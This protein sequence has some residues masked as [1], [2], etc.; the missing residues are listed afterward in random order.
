MSDPVLVK[1]LR[2][3]QAFLDQLPAKV[4]KNILRSA[5]RQGAN[6][7]K[8]EA[9]QQ[10]ASNGNVK[11]GELS[12]GLKVSTNAKG[13]RVTASLKAKGKHGHIAHWIEFGTRPH[14]IKGK[15]G[16]ALAFA[17]G[18]YKAINHPGMRPRP[19]L[20][21]ALDGAAGMALVAV[22]EA[23]KKRLTKE[24]IDAS[25]VEIDEI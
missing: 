23:I 25:D 11:T 8:A 2:E 12:K 13:G 5:L 7:I 9:Q 24:G 16:Q 21:P 3:L 15:N 20:R 14:L 10:L 6:A 18:I 22:G 4:E 19:F 1:G 17:G